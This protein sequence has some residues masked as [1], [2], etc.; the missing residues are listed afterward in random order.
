[1]FIPSCF[2][3]GYCPLGQ[4][5]NKSELFIKAVTCPWFWS[6]CAG[7]HALRLAWFNSG[8]LEMELLARTILFVVFLGALFGGLVVLAAYAAGA[9]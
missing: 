6:P 3:S 1:M 8:G 7:L 9:G 4:T 5:E 2:R